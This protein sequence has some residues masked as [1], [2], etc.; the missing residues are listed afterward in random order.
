MILVLAWLV[1]PALASDSA[2]TGLEGHPRERLPLRVWVQ[3]TGDA[4]LDAAARKALD[5]WNAVARA[6]L[7]TEVF[8]PGTPFENA[9][10]RVSLEPATARGLMGIT[11]L[12]TD[13][14]GTIQMPVTIVVV[15]PAARGQTSREAVLYQVLAHE[16][17]HALGLPHVTDPRSL[18]C[19]ERGAVDLGDPAV[20]EAY[21]QARRRPDVGS[22][23]AQLAEHYARRWRSP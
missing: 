23:R 11:Q 13:D 15:E 5:D 21:V 22:V 6:A 4:G 10:V 18:M 2:L 3:P 17:G 9:Q 19:C 12:S 7:G 20:R 14:V 8:V 1:A 16:L